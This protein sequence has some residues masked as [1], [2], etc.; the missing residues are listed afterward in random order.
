ML[1]AYIR[2]VEYDPDR[3]RARARTGGGDAEA[4]EVL[5]TGTVEDICL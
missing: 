5:R 3:K 4:P 1:Q 2:Q